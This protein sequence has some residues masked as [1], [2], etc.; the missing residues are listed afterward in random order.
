MAKKNRKLSMQALEEKA[1]MAGDVA[2]SVS[3]GDLYINEAADSAGDA[4]NVQVY[5][6]SN[7]G[8][9]VQG[10]GDTSIQTPVFLNGMEF[11]MYRSYAD[12][13]GVSDDV[14]VNLGGG[15]DSLSML[16]YNGG[17]D[18]D[19]VRVNMGGGG[20][21]NDNVSINGLST[22]SNLEVNTGA[23]ND[24][25]SVSNST[26]GDGRWED[27]RVN[28]G[29]GADNVN[30]SLTTV[31]DNVELT[32][33]SN[34]SEVDVDRANIQ[35]LNADDLYADLGNGD[36][37]FTMSWSDLDDADIDMGYDYA[38]AGQDDDY[39]FLGYNTADDVDV[40]GRDGNDDLRIAFNEF[41]D[42]D[43]WGGSGNDRY[44]FWQNAPGQDSND[45]DGG[46]VSSATEIAYGYV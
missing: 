5:Q 16:N 28:T 45:I 26:I 3:G 43:F 31:R 38:G 17:I 6:L 37:V 1:M 27:L 30:V 11:T 19:F 46:T 14:W 22:R 36:D 20:A 15:S 10:I 44:Y 21:D 34:A 13:Y 41:D 33:Y 4:Q 23:G 25:V 9:R 12:F 2:V 39:V 32:M 29:S 18:A 7:G 8:I 42:L 24:S 35:Y 40:T